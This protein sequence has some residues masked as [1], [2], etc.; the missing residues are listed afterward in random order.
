[1]AGRHSLRDCRLAKAQVKQTHAVSRN[2][3]LLCMIGQEERT[4]RAVEDFRSE[5]SDESLARV[6]LQKLITATSAG[7]NVEFSS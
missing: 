4:S 3:W 5:P 6:G 2:E 1:M 7:E